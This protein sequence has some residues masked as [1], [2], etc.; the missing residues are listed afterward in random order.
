MGGLDKRWM[1]ITLTITLV[2]VGT[3]I[4]DQRSKEKQ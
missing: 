1:L 3:G 2:T 4:P